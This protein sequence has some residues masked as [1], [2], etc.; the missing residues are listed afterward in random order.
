MTGNAD[1]LPA[2][3]YKTIR[4]S[5]SGLAVKVREWEEI[6]TWKCSWFWSLDFFEC[7]AKR[8]PPVTG[9]SKFMWQIQPRT[10]LK[11]LNDLHDPLIFLKKNSYEIIY[12]NRYKSK[13]NERSYGCHKYILNWCS[14]RIHNSAILLIKPF[15]TKHPAR[16]WAIIES[17]EERGGRL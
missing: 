13:K 9:L 4:E 17:G 7:R 15:F 11:V 6:R 8:R 10:K 3:C 14:F 5:K 2:R 12:S 16:D 1:T